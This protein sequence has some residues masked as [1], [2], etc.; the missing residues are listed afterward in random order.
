MCG[1]D[2]ENVNLKTVGGSGTWAKH[3]NQCGGFWFEREPTEFLSLDSINSV[4]VPTPNFSLKQMDLVCSNDNSLLECVERDDLPAG[5]RYW[6]CPDCEGAFYPKGQLALVTHHNHDVHGEHIA[7]LVSTR[8]RTTLAGVLVFVG[9]TLMI[10]TSQSQIEFNATSDQV[11]PS[12]G[13]NILTLLLL[14]ITYLAGTILAVLGRKVPIVL[15]GWSVIIICLV[16][17]S[18]IIFGP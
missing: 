10:A 7:G 12:S 1:G 17:F 8:S 14:G 3:C 18:V 6:R 16:G 4:D 5:T 11:L 15:L 13:P 9:A 2:F